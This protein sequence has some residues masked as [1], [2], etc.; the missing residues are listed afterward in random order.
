M[1]PFE[2]NFNSPQEQPPVDSDTEQIFIPTKYRGLPSEVVEGLW[3]N[4]TYIDPEKNKTETEKRQKAIAEIKRQE[5]NRESEKEKQLAEQYTLL[6]DNQK[7]EFPSAQ[8]DAMQVL[9]E[10]IQ[11]R[12]EI[13]DLSR[14]ES[15]VLSKLQHNYREFKKENPDKPFAFD[16]QQDIDRQ[17]YNNLTQRLS[18]DVLGAKQK[19]KDQEKANAIRAELGI[20]QKEVKITEV[21]TEQPKQIDEIAESDK[22][23]L[24][25]TIRDKFNQIGFSYKKTGRSL[26]DALFAVGRAHLT[27]EDKPYEVI[28]GEIGQYFDA[29]GIA[30]FDQLNSLLQLLENGIDPERPFHTA[31]FEVLDE[32]RAGLGA[33]LGTAGVQ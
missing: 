4:P 12:K 17:V 30:K 16:F 26:Q 14:E 29:H 27:L 7:K 18:F 2:K 24:L 31:P 3:T 10:C 11:G 22:E 32:D 19:V 23:K 28:K 20:P 5:Q 25:Q 1:Q 8:K 15:Y 9:T 21:F 13:E 6:S 33:G